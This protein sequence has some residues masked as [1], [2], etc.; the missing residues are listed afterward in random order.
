MICFSGARKLTPQERD[1]V[2]TYDKSAI[3][4]RAENCLLTKSVSK[5]SLYVIKIN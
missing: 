2:A 1:R 3:T 4:V 5:G